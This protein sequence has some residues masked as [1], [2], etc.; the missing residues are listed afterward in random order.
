MGVKV[1]FS[2]QPVNYLH[3]PP[4]FR[5]EDGLVSAAVVVIEVQFRES[6]EKSQNLGKNS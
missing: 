1:I 3:K 2:G 6:R 4:L 5:L